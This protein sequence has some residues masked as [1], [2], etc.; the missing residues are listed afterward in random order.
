[1]AGYEEE[2]QYAT[3]LGHKMRY[4]FALN[5][6]ASFHFLELRTAPQGH[7]GYRYICNEMHQK[8]SSIHPRIG[9]AMKFV[10]KDEDPELTRMAAELATQYK[11]DKL[12][13]IA[14]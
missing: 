2:A 3:L 4:R 1:M 14:K 9:E 13:K 8:L 11:L 7:P 5:A 6:R 10:N 12:D